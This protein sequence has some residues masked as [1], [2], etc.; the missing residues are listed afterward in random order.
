MRQAF[1]AQR[2]GKA[3]AADARD[4]DDDDASGTERTAVTGGRR[5]V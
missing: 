2:A 1:P 4:A 3:P 5:V